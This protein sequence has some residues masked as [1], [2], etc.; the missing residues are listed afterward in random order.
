MDD[1]NLV[2][3][4]RRRKKAPYVRA[5]PETAREPTPAQVE[6]RIRFGELA[7][8]A[9]GAKKTGPDLPAAEAVRGMKGERS[10][11]RRERLRKWEAEALEREKGEEDLRK[12]KAILKGMEG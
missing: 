10:E 8:K 5:M 7:G 2:L 4:K 9:R 11:L 12:L 6:V 3:V 1:W